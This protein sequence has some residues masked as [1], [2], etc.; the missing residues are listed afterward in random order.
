MRNGL[1]QES[2]FNR[3]NIFIALAGKIQYVAKLNFN[4][5]V[6]KGGLVVSDEL[7]REILCEIKGLKHAQQETNSRLGALE[8]AQQETNSRLGTL[9]HAQ[10]ETNSR[11]GAL[12]HAQQETNSRLGTLEHAQEETNNRL[13]TLEHAQQETNNRLGTLEQEYVSF[14]ED[15]MQFKTEV[16]FRFDNLQHQVDLVANRVVV[17]SSLEEQM[18]IAF[19]ILDRHERDIEMLKKKIG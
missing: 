18:K 7:L 5:R 2:C 12:E 10:Q 16:F 17:L 15:Y 4:T 3:E 19:D 6:L 14:R 1:A 13:G 9:E 8:H 11:L